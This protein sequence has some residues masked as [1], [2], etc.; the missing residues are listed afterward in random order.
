MLAQPAAWRS[1]VVA[2]AFQS[3]SW[4]SSDRKRVPISFDGTPNE[5]A[6]VRSATWSLVGSSSA[7]GYRGRRIPGSGRGSNQAFKTASRRPTPIKAS[8]CVSALP[9]P[10]YYPLPFLFMSFLANLLPRCFFKPYVRK[11][12]KTAELVALHETFC[13]ARQPPP[14]LH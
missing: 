10:L 5:L 2:N 3:L 13:K 12:P 4:N 9:Q 8:F 6:S 14:D 11:W 7:S 1:R